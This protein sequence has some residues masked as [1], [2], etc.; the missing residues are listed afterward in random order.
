MNSNEPTS[1]RDRILSKIERNEVRMHSRIYFILLGGVVIVLAVLTLLL[2]VFLGNLL[3]F[4]LRI[5][6]HDGLLALGTQGLVLFVQ[7]FPWWLLLITIALVILV[8]WLARRFSFVYRTPALFVFALLVAGALLAGFTLDRGTPLNDHL[9]QDADDGHLPAPLSGLY[10]GSRHAPPP[11]SGG[12][13]GTITHIDADRISLSDPDISTT[14][15][16]V[17]LPTEPHDGPLHLTLG[18]AVFVIG[19]EVNGAIHAL[20]I[21][22]LD[23]DGLPPHDGHK[24]H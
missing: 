23:S 8:A 2:S 21:H 10:Q 20:D 22:P 3:S 15:L 18:E 16:I 13:R 9:L 4:T 17:F 1:V 6:G 5:N 12:Y 7:V 14:T 11:G 19:S 24:D